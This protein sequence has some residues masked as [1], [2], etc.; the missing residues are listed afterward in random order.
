VELFGSA[1]AQLGAVGLLGVFVLMLATGRLMPRS[2]AKALVDQANAGR[3]FYRSAAAAS[4]ERADLIARQNG[5][6]LQAMRTVETLVRA[7]GPG[8]RRDEAA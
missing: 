6:L 8:P 3:D 1:W 4:D 7:W 5:E 2:T